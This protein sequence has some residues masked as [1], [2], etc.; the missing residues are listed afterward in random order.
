MDTSKDNNTNKV[1]VG[2]TL[3]ELILDAERSIKHNAYYKYEMLAD[4][5]EQIYE[6]RNTQNNK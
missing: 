1:K 6:A 2:A 4:L 5:L 3:S